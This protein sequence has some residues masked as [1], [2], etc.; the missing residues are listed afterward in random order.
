MA[1][2]CRTLD[3][4]SMLKS[5]VEIGPRYWGFTIINGGLSYSC[6]QLCSNLWLLHILAGDSIT[7][8]WIH[9]FERKGECPYG[10]NISQDTDN[11]LGYEGSELYLVSRRPL[12][13][14]EKTMKLTALAILV[15]ILLALKPFTNSSDWESGSRTKWNKG[16]R[17]A[18]LRRKTNPFGTPRTKYTN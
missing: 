14:V 16:R 5:R 8:Y 6:G 18:F 7:T 10:N 15:P 9:A 3:N 1:F 13:L 17:S 11:S 12:I 2:S 4:E